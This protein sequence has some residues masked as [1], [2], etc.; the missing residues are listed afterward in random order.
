[1]KAILLEIVSRV[2]T[3]YDHCHRCA[4]LF[5][6]AGL[7]KEFNENLLEGYPQDLREEC[8][9]LSDWIRELSGLY[10][11]RLVIKII[12]AH[13]PVGM[14]KCLRH[15]IRK[16]PTFIINGK[17]TFVGWDK[18]KL[19][20]LIDKHIQTSIAARKQSLPITTS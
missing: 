18:D 1:M 2:L 4:I 7:Q 15:W 16:Y 13:S 11:H 6:E 8:A 14:V 17:E 10:K 20:G 19:E 3:S 5:D 12:D 9:Q